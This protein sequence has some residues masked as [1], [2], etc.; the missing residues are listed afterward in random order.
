MEIV[1]LKDMKSII[2]AIKSLLVHLMTRK[3]TRLLNGF[4]DQECSKI[5]SVLV[6]LKYPNRTV[7]EP[8]LVQIEKCY[9]KAN[10]VIAT[11]L[12]ATIL[13]QLHQIP[14]ISIG[15]QDKVIVHK[16]T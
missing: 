9:K 13:A 15:Y 7:S 12:H 3:F 2:D 5:I 6:I 11:R 4:K 1:T 10:F 8:S 14:F 16:V